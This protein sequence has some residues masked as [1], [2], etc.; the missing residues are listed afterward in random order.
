M[1]PA[2]SPASTPQPRIAQRGSSS[3]P[4]TCNA[5]RS[6]WQ[7]SSAS[8]RATSA[9]RTWARPVLRAATRPRGGVRTTR[10]RA[11][12]SAAA[13]RIAGVASDE[14]SST[15]TTSWSAKVCEKS[16]P[17]QA[18]SVSCPSRT[19]R[20]TETRG[21]AVAD[22]EV[23]GRPEGPFGAARLHHEERA[24]DSRP[25]PR[26][27]GAADLRLPAGVPRHRLQD[28][29]YPFLPP[30]GRVDAEG[31][32]LLRGEERQASPHERAHHLLALGGHEEELDAIAEVRPA[33]LR[34]LP[35][36]AAERAQP[37]GD[38]ADA[39]LEVEVGRGPAGAAR[40]RPGGPGSARAG[41]TDRGPTPPGR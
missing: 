17:R 19:G 21:L 35:H 28:L 29:V 6:R 30:H 1:P 37:V 34:R 40:A 8:M 11:S 10:R 14:P 20:S 3:R 18:G 7:T 16:E 23:P 38:A 25:P 9:P 32:L 12:L 15:A 24:G 41:A 2:A 4:S 22:E 33:H 5:S 31:Q 26:A 27:R 36:H 39:E 13:A